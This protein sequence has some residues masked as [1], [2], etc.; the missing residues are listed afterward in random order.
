MRKEL[1]RKCSALA[2]AATLILSSFPAFGTVTEPAATYQETFA[3]GTGIAVKAGDASVKQVSGKTFEGNSDGAAVF[4]GNRAKTWDAVDFPYEGL[5]IL[6][7]MAYDIE[8][9]GY[10]DGDV[11]I[12]PGAQMVL[13]TDTTF[14]WI[15]HVDMIAGQAFRLTAT[16]MVNPQENTAL[17][18]QTNDAGQAVPFFIGEI[19]VT[20]NPE[21]AA[22]ANAP[23]PAAEPF[24]TITFE[25]GTENGFAG[26]AGT[27]ILTVAGDA[28]HTEGGSKSLKTEG[29]TISWHGPAL[30]I[31]KHIDLG[32]EYAVSVW[33][34][35]VEPAGTDLQL[36][37]QVGDGS[38]A[39]YMNLGKQTVSVDDGWVELTGTYRYTSAGDEFV[40]L[41]VESPSETASFYV[42]DISFTQ[43]SARQLAIEQDIQSLRDVFKDDFLIGTAIS[44]KDIIGIR[45]DL[46]KKHFNAVTAE[47]AMKPAELQPTKGTF[48]FTSPDMLVNTAREF[49]M[50]VHG[51][52]L[53]WHQQTP[54]WMTN[55][56]DGAIL[57]REEALDNMRTHI[58]TVM[59]HFGD[60][61][62]SWDVVNEA[63]NDGP[64]NPENW[65]GALRNS[66]WRQAIGDDYVEQAFLAAREVLD[67]N[68]A[69]DIK[70]YYNDYNLD[71]QNKA[72]AT[73]TMV[74]AINDAYAAKHPGKLLIDGIGMQAHYG[75]GTNP[76]N[77][78]LSL[79]RFIALGVEV[80]ITEMDVQAGSN[81]GL[82]GEQAQAQAYLYA[83]LFKLYREHADKI[84]RV[85]VWGMD[86]GNSWRSDS[87]PL[88]FDKDL[89]AKPA[90]AAVIDP[91]TAI[92]SHTPVTV[93]ALRATAVYGTPVLDGK[94]DPVWRK[95]GAMDINRF[96]MAWQGATGIAKAMWDG[97]NLYV[98]FQVT[99]AQL[100]KASA[101]PWEQ[102]SVE[103]FLDENNQKTSFYDADDGQFRVNYENAATFNPE[104]IAEGFASAVAVSGTSYVV[105]L[106]IPFRTLTPAAGAEI[107]FDAQINDGKDGARQSVAT[108]N[109]TVGTGY[110]DTSV[111]GILTLQAAKPATTW[112]FWVVGLVALAGVVLVF[113]LIL[114]ARRR[115][116]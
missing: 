26:R 111:F 92:A 87:S 81:R 31:E 40:T 82:T 16:Y 48:L 65:Q 37:T 110:Q 9:T 15:S 36:S 24:A 50:Q 64:A 6:E 114:K 102:D 93:D 28:N 109:A 1:R 7:G 67:E 95:A 61:V 115:R 23:R 32:T 76:T 27:E 20:P 83:K 112:V 89:Q 73:E 96:Q 90:Y 108:W 63:V 91:D 71:N 69:W 106:K 18:V 56:E 10:L 70:L 33:V 51:H 12:S 99:D 75:T 57:S 8:V 98:L 19:R 41:Y 116:S 84:A 2:L 88:L 104:G 34:K 68:S 77:V 25:D 78:A 45:A 85:T 30:R 58:R 47:N 3:S 39:S 55:A 49:G 107:G 38:G 29:R 100:D 113:L 53:V 22:K 13:G 103:V 66:P 5:G 46:L 79:E 101:N 62:I 42:D 11:N 97:Q 21:A 43:T 52:V 72:K 35:L 60:R 74:K 105:E 44:S 54:A 94:V 4:V 80:S 59:E 14:T 86:D 17:R